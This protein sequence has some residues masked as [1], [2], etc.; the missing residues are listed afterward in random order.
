MKFLNEQFEISTR[1]IDK[2]SESLKAAKTV[3]EV[4]ALFNS[5][6]QNIVNIGSFT[7]S[8]NSLEQDAIK[9]KNAFDLMEGSLKSLGQLGEVVEAIINKNWIGMLISLIARLASSFSNISENAAAAQNILDVLF[10]VIEAILDDMGESLDSIFKPLLDITKALG[11]FIG[12]ILRLLINIITPLANLINNFN[13]LIPIINIVSLLIAGLTDILGFLFNFIS[14]IIRTITFDLIDLG[15]MQTNNL[16]KVLDSISQEN[17]YSDYQSNSTNYHVSGD[18]KINIYYE[19][20]FVN[21]DS[22]EIALALRDEI[23]LAESNGY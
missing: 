6:K 10:D 16:E 21:G 9:A 18:L 19:H 4:D 11:Q 2:L 15:K 8:M 7:S 3:D 1:N 23:R 13:F 12:S 17:S 20:S 14:D 22:R 5:I